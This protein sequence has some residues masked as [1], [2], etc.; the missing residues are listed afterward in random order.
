MKI[1]K[2]LRKKIK[3]YK[4]YKKLDINYYKPLIDLLNE[5]TNKL[6]TKDNCEPLIASLVNKISICIFE[7]RRRDS[8]KVVHIIYPIKVIIR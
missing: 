2:I 6:N 1:W 8:I 5:Y 3:S 4:C 7:A